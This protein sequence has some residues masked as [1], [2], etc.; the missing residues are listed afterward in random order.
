MA[1]LPFI[2]EPRLKSVIDRLGNEEIGIIEIERKGYLTVQERNF[3]QQI[4]RSDQGAG[5]VIKLSRSIASKYGISLERSYNVA[6]GC[7][8]ASM[9]EDQ[10]QEYKEKAEVEFAD[11][12]NIT[13]QNLGAMQSQSEMVEALCM[14]INRINSDFNPNDLKEIHPDLVAELSNLYKDELNKSTDRIKELHDQA[15]VSV[16]E[17]EKKQ[18]REKKSG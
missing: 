1:R 16:E 9:D 5:H 2:V 18:A 11:E 6:M 12:I 13:I 10:D 4:Q 15:D 7:L 17:V 14:I 8:G 3:V